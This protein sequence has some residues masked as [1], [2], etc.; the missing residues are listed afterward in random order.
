MLRLTSSRFSFLM[1]IYL[2]TMQNLPSYSAEKKPLPPLSEVRIRSSLDGSMQPALEWAPASATRERTPLLVFLHSWGGNFKQNN[3]HWQREAVRRNWIYLHPDFRGVNDKPEACGSALARRDI[4]DA[5]DDLAS[6]YKVDSTRIYL[7]GSSGGGHM[8][9]LMASYYPDRF[10]AVSSWVGIS[11]LGEWHRFHVKAG[12]PQRYARL[13]EKCCGGPPGHSPV[14]DAEYRE[15]SPIFHLQNTGTLPIDLNAGVRDGHEG[16][17][18]VS[19]SLRAFNVIARQNGDPQVS[20]TEMQQLWEQQKL[21]A[22]LPSDREP[23]PAYERKIFLRRHS[24]DSRVTIFDGGHQGQPYSA[25]EW[26]SK[27]TRPTKQ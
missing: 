23:D 9:M 8:T 14:V 4:L 22:P 20:E 3:S 10:S 12:E 17:V 26:L 15:R 5:M 19:Q 1:S 27:Q 2:I 6:R 18:P 21:T 16:S 11:D 13:L 24:G 25:T 7:A